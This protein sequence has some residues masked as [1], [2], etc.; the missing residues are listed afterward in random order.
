METKRKGSISEYRIIIKFL[1]LGCHV[2]QPIGDNNRY[3]LVVERID[4][5]KRIQ[6][7]TAS[8]RNGVVNFRVSNVGKKN[9][10]IISKTYKNQIDYFAAYCPQNDKIYLVNIK[11]T[12]KR[13][14]KLRITEPKNNQKK[15]IKY[16]KDYEM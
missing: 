16:A 7:K 13:E 8:L 12:G 3:D 5:F 14:C 11:D 2:L 15:L 10:F 4:G 9:G 6:C 1:E